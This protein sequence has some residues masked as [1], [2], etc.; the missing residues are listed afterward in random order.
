MNILVVYHGDNCTDGWTSA[1][2][3]TV[4]AKQAGHGE[5]EL[6]PLTYKKGQE[7]ELLF[8]IADYLHEHKKQYDVIYVLDIS[9]SL[10]TLELIAK[11]TTASII[12]LDHHKTAFDRYVPDEPRTKYEI[13]NVSLYDGQVSIALNNGMSGAGMTHAYF[14]PDT[15]VPLLVQ[16]VQDRDIW[17]YDMEHTKAIDRYLR[18]QEQTIENWT[19]INAT[20]CHAEGYV[21][22]VEEGRILLDLHELRVKDIV[23]RSKWVTIGGATGLMAECGYVYAS[24][25]GHELC[26]ISGTFGL[27]YFTLEDEGDTSM[28]Q[29]S[30]RSEGNYDVE[31]MAKKL[32]GGGHKNAAGFII[33]SEKFFLG[34]IE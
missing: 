18:S 13:R 6:Y 9:L 24:D 15:E 20:M 12:M 4:A 32:G 17:S 8:H 22:I 7:S 2:L 1:W 29:V 16:H 27:T 5:P 31:A 33:D 3:A 34:E 21:E 23:Y 19:D 30:L 26:N 11:N 14:F 25:V 28:L 10:E